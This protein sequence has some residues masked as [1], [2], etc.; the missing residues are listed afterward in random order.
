MAGI[1]VNCA[2]DALLGRLLD[3]VKVRSTC[4]YLRK[5]TKDLAK[6]LEKLFAG[7]S[8]GRISVGKIPQ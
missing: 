5:D 4:V 8:E 2:P 6:A 7:L 1:N 3:Q